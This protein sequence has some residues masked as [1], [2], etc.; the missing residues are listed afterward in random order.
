MEE[1]NSNLTEELKLI[2]KVMKKGA[3]AL[4]LKGLVKNIGN[5]QINNSKESILY[6]F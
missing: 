5:F 4:G 6:N 3:D 2:K 1:R